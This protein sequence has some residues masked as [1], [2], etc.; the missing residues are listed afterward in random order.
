MKKDK[1]DKQDVCR[2]CDK[3]SLAMQPTEQMPRFTLNAP[4]RI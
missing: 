2:V 4:P 3:E 1:A